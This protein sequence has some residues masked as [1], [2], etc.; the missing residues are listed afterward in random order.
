MSFALH[1]RTLSRVGVV[2]SGRIGP[3]IAL[4]FT[5]ILAPHGVPVVVNDVIPAA[6]ESG[7]LRTN[8][9]EPAKFVHA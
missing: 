8:L 3:D 7:R 5:K 6:L 1:G 9:K 2:G 4:F